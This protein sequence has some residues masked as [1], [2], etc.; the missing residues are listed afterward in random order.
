MM[1]RHYE[2]TDETSLTNFRF[3]RIRATRDLPRFDVK[4]GDLGGFVESYENL[5]GDAWVAGNAKVYGNARVFGEA[6]ISRNARVFENASVYGD[7]RISGSA[8]VRGNAEVWG[9][10]E[11]FGKAQVDGKTELEYDAWIRE[12]QDILTVFPIGSE[13]VTATLYRTKTGHVLEVGCWMGTVE[14]LQDEVQKR[15]RYWPDETMTDEK[16]IDRWKAEYAA[17]EVLC[18]A[19]IAGWQE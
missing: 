13:S 19:R 3:R 8:W 16:N 1:N 17:L 2:L 18:K 6:L 5:S 10:A 11:V 4:A 14:T 9:N 12:A 7:A 15:S